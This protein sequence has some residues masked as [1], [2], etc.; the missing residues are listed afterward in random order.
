MFQK[1]FLYFLTFWH[2]KFLY[3]GSLF[4][5]RPPCF[6][7]DAAAAAAAARGGREHAEKDAKDAETVG[8]DTILAWD[9]KEAICFLCYFFTVSKFFFV[10]KT[11]LM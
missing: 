8:K 5:R 1:T 2:L 7:A 4:F 11:V 6:W 9:Y 3:L 10:K